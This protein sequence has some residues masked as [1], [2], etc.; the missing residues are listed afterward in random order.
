MGGRTR[1]RRCTGCGLPCRG[2]IGPTGKKCHYLVSCDSGSPPPSVAGSPPPHD[3]SGADLTLFDHFPPLPEREHSPT[4]SWDHDTNIRPSSAP[5][6]SVWPPATLQNSFANFSFQG[7]TQVPVANSFAPIS[8]PCPISVVRSAPGVRVVHAIDRPISVAPPIN[9]LGASTSN[10]CIPQPQ[11]GIVGGSYATAGGNSYVTVSGNPYVTVSGNPGPPPPLPHN[12]WARPVSQ[13]PEVDHTSRPGGAPY[14]NTYIPHHPTYPLDSTVVFCQPPPHS[15][16]P[17]PSF[18]LAQPGGNR[19]IYPHHPSTMPPG[20]Y[21]PRP[22]GGP[23]HRLCR[24]SA[25]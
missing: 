13:A 24:H 6:M 15:V 21:P 22:P 4:M 8:A 1:T 2:H 14:T 23:R 20:T 11:Y 18:T 10:Q 16:G 9:M 19:D 17:S 12:S 3:R 7:P 25:T 5:P